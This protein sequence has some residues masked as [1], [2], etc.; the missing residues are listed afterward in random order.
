M[1]LTF[2]G[3]NGPELTIHSPCLTWDRVIGWDA[4]LMCLIQTKWKP[5][6][7]IAK[8][9]IRCVTLIINDCDL[10]NIKK[11]KQTLIV[12]EGVVFISLCW[13]FCLIDI[14]ILTFSINY[15]IFSFQNVNGKSH[16]F[17]FGLGTSNFE[18]ISFLDDWIQLT[19]ALPLF[20]QNYNYFGLKFKLLIGCR[21]NLLG[22]VHSYTGILF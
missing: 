20:K 4:S 18:L 15:R 7:L 16:I 17:A 12:L 22:L 6:Y 11:T 2:F 1:Q 21:T 14:Y 9:C 19:F 8:I 5:I 10:K 13:G 3:S